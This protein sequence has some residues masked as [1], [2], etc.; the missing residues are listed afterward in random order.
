VDPLV[1]GDDDPALSALDGLVRG[2]AWI[3]ISKPYHTRSAEPLW[4]RYRH[5]EARIY[6]HPEVATRLNDAF[7][8]EHGVVSLRISRPHFPWPPPVRR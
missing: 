2:R 5:A 8:P 7:R 6:G 1:S 3:L 4:R